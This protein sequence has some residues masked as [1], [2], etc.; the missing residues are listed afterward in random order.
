MSN[1][2]LH[3]ILTNKKAK[4]KKRS[5]IAMIEGVKVNEIAP[6]LEKI[7]SE[8][9]KKVEE[10]TLDMANNMS[11]IVTRV[12][13]DSLQVIDRFHVQKLITEAV[14]EIRIKYRHLALKED[15][16]KRKE[17][18]EKNKKYV[19]VTY[20]NGDTKKQLLARSRYLL[21]KPK[22]KWTIRQ[23]E[24]SEILFEKFPE[25]KKAYDLS[26]MFRNC[27]E[28]GTDVKDAKRRFNT[29]YRK[30]EEE[31]IE[32]LILAADSIKLREENILN[33]F[34]NRSTNAPAES[35]NAKL[36]GFRT[37]VRGVVD[38]KFHLFR[39]FKIFG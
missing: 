17:F 16:E 30:T 29:W 35:F 9:R 18:K 32:P 1:G 6:I 20:T 4:G 24:R 39:V 19:P 12:F 15:N 8:A 36:K 7:P 37:L 27:Y 38:K 31:N 11:A 10:V 5:L 34:I 33:Y 22:S 26:M 25:I 13:P 21:F 23:K 3:T 28:K 2:E 14:Q